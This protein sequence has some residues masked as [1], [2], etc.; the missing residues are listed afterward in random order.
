MAF[1]ASICGGNCA[2]WLLIIE[3]TQDVAVNLRHMVDFGGR[4]FMLTVCSTG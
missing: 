4:R 3:R 2:R 1:N